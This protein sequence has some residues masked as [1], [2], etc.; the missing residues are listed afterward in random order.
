VEARIPAA[1]RDE[2]SA[3][4]HSGIKNQKVWPGSSHLD[5]GANCVARD[6]HFQT[7]SSEVLGQP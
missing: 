6:V 4:R 1:V 7:G 5:E 3:P 2:L